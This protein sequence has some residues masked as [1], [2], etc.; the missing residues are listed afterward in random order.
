M[1]VILLVTRKL[2]RLYSKNKTARAF[3]EML[4]GSGKS[5]IIMYVA[6]FA[7]VMGMAKTVNIYFS[8][9]Q[10]L[11]WEKKHFDVLKELT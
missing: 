2:S 7:L 5:I 10:I 3:V 11:D 8:N 1:A 6:T 4:A 9:K